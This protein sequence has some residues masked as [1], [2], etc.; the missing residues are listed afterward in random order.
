MQVA[1]MCEVD[2]SSTQLLVAQT[3]RKYK[4]GTTLISLTLALRKFV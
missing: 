3:A 2:I 4:A 1:Q